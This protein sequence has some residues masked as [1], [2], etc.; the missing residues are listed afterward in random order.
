MDFLIEFTLMALAAITLEN[1][2]F[3]RGFGLFPAYSLSSRPRTRAA[4]C[5]SVLCMTVMTSIL[6]WW[7]SH[8]L[9]HILP[10]EAPINFIRPLAF[11]LCSIAAY[12]IFYP[13]A[14]RIKPSVFGEFKGLIPAAAFNCTVLGASLISAHQNMSFAQ[15]VGF[16]F[17]MGVGYFIASLIISF[18]R[19]LIHIADIPRV[20]RGLPIMLLYIGLAS[21]ALYGLV[22]HQLPM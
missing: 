21:L 10:E 11:L 17:G 15:W 7:V 8:T 16:G 12:L 2:V 9:S 18:G 22:G 6:T 5:L 19:S 3:A 20:F 14:A 1:A 13:L 4:F